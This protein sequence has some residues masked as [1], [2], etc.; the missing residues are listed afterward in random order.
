MPTFWSAGENFAGSLMTR[1]RRRGALVS[2]S[3]ALSESED[4]QQSE[5]CLRSGQYKVSLA[6]KYVVQGVDKAYSTN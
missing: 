3:G 2:T 6:S 4:L 1:R 5:H